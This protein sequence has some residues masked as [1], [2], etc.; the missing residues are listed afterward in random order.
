[1]APAAPRQRAVVRR[2]GERLHKGM[3]VLTQGEEGCDLDMLGE[4]LVHPHLEAE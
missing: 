1:M 2:L 3:R 4:E